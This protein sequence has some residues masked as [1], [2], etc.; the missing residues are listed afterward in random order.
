M[1]HILNTKE[2]INKMKNKCFEHN[3]EKLHIDVISDVL[4][5]NQKPISIYT[6][7]GM[8]TLREDTT[9]FPAIGNTRTFGFYTDPETAFNA[10]ENNALDIMECIY[11]YMKNEKI[12]EGLYMPTNIRWLFKWN[13]KK[14]K[15]VPTEE[16]EFLKHF[17]G[18]AMG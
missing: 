10:V 14:E 2:I 16:P 4:N 12:E 9:G 13:E 5:E 17:V 18:F 8:A 7:T 3:S 6:I 1:T 11:N 15:F